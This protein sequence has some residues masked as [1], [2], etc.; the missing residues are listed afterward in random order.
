[1]IEFDE[2]DIGEYRDNDV[3]TDPQFIGAVVW[4]CRDDDRQAVHL[5]TEHEHRHILGNTLSALLHR[6]IE[7]YDEKQLTT[8]A[9]DDPLRDLI[10]LHHRRYP[11]PHWAKNDA[12]C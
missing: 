10:E 3:L 6:V 9:P 4:K 11:V 1:M 2:I 12:A 5:L 8:T 7:H